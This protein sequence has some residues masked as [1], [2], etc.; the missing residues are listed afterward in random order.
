MSQ[1]NFE[2][3]PNKVRD[4]LVRNYKRAGR[5]VFDDYKKLLFEK[6]KAF[7]NVIKP[8]PKWIP[9][10]VWQKLSSFFID[11]EAISEAGHIV[12]ED[13]PNLK[14]IAEAIDESI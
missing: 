12:A 5:E 9:R 14:K 11:T 4:R 13:I 2:R 1:E 8:R 7:N 10:F 6:I 3:L